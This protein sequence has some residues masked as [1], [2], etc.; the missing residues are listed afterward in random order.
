[1]ALVYILS[2]P[3]KDDMPVGLVGEVQ[4]DQPPACITRHGLT[5]HAYHD[6]KTKVMST[7]QHV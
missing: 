6:Y 2:A 3:G 1:M 4:S 5:D 7:V